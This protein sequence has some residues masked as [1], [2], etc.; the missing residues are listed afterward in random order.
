MSAQHDPADELR[1]L[2]ATAQADLV[3]RG[4]VTAAEV[5]G[6]AVE[7]IEA[8]DGDIGAVIHRRFDAARAEA[9][10]PDLAGP[11]AGVPFL[12]KDLYATSAGDPQHNGSRA[13][14][15]A[16]FV[17]TEDSELVAR[18]RRAG[19]VLVG[20]SN[21]PEFGL[22]PTTEPVA[23]GATRNPWDASR[24]PGGSSGG[25]AA[26]VA[27][28]LVPA[29]HAS[30]G[31]GSI[32]IPASACGLVGLKVSRGR[33]SL[34][35]AGDESALSVHHVVTRSVRDTAAILDATAGPAPGD[36]AVAPPPVRPWSA[37]VGADPGRL[38]VGVLAA[39]PG[40]DLHPECRAAAEGAGRLLESLGHHVEDSHP[41]ALDHPEE[42]GRSFLAR[43]ATGARTAMIAAGALAGREL[44]EDDVEPT[45]WLMASLGDATSG[46]DLALAYAASAAY[47]RALASWWAG[48]FDLLVTPTLGEPPWPLGD[49]AAASAD[50]ALAVW[51]RTTAL[52]PFTTH[53]NISGQPA[54][55]L[56]L[57]WTPDGLPVG[58]QLVAAYGCEDVLV[59]VA[60]QLEAAAPW[61]HRRPP[62]TPA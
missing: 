21:T 25:A 7:R 37:E 12:V 58:V 54:V 59:R 20:R 53:F 57:H 34:A 44:G 35:P 15:D 26:A 11:F 14:R 36:T 22:L 32:R 41:A 1:W 8:L 16:G 33:T 43:W 60:S 30:D 45:T 6:A 10:A 51:Q 52:V 46:V 42:T 28:G 18:Y 5:V 39:S 13:V 9:A 17:A 62:A 23:H 49:L 56:P 24:S 2:D 4:E 38:R 40:G 48:G 31:G 29:A 3:R 19:F 61:A 27:A 55:S 47:T 50:E